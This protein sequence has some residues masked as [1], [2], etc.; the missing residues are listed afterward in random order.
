MRTSL[1][2]HIECERKRLRQ[3]HAVLTCLSDS[4]S[5]SVD[6]QGAQH[7]DVVDVALDLVAAAIERLDLVTLRAVRECS[8]TYDS[9]QS[10]RVNLA[11]V[12]FAEARA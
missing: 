9:A 4:L 8:A 6:A 7:A 12:R 10:A 2:E 1:R 5:H 11:G 3:A